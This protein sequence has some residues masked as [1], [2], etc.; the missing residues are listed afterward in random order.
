M[1][2]CNLWTVS[3]LR[4]LSDSNMHTYMI[5]WTDSCIPCHLLLSYISPWPQ[6]CFGDSLATGRMSQVRMIEGPPRLW[7]FSSQTAWWV[8][9][10]RHCG[11]SQAVGFPGSDRLIGLP[12]Y[13]V[14]DLAGLGGLPRLWSIRSGR[15]W[16]P[17]RLWSLS[18]QTG[19]GSLSVMK[20]PRLLG[21]LGHIDYGAAQVRQVIM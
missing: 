14:S 18:D 19:R 16:G 5:T 4:K 21:H 2:W 9:W 3:L 1:W 11:V 6:S 17:P 10:I 8:S 15:S 13:R 20:L 12:G 7:D